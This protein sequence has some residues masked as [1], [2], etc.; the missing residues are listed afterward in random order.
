MGSLGARASRDDGLAG[1]KAQ[2]VSLAAESPAQLFDG[3][4]GAASLGV[5]RWG[6]ANIEAAQVAERY[7]MEAAARAVGEGV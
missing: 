5:M 3:S 7:E 4:N 1:M 2:E 6:I